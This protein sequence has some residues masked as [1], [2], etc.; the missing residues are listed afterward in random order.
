[1]NEWELKFNFDK[2]FVEDLNKAMFDR[3]P[4]TIIAHGNEYKFV[5]VKKYKTTYYCERVQDD[6][7]N[8]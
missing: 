4:I 2:A 6:K 5:L 3:T 8:S 1:M 7:D